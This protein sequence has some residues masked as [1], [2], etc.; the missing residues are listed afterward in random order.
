MSRR[1]DSRT[2]I[3]SPEGRLYQVEYA[4]EAISNAGAAV[5]VL[6][7]D[8]VVLA[9]E[10]RVTSKLLAASKST[11]KMYKIDDNVACAVAGI[12]A[13]ANILINTARLQA[14][15]YTLAYQEAI[16]VEQLVQLLCD[17]KQGYT[18]FGGLRPFGVSFLFAG[19]DKNFGFQL[20]LSDPSGNY[21]G[22]KAGAIGANSQAAQSMLK[23]DYKDDITREE[24]V[25]L[26][27][28]VLSKTMDSTSLS[29]EKLELAEIVLTPTGEVKYQV[30]TANALNKLLLKHGITQPA[31]DES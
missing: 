12:M 17:T 18:Q 7:K 8:G 3:F 19:Y 9:A 29:A 31:A 16:P 23:Q 21:G 4:M 20:Y 11:E 25:Q 26:A 6:A 1:Y 13:D 10:K 28:K 22:W 14:Q 24:A 2:T 30:C 27:L 5:G 15:R